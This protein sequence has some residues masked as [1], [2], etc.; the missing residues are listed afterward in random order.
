MA[1]GLPFTGKND[2]RRNN[3][4]RG[5]G[6]NLA[7]LIKRVGNEIDP[8][9]RLTMVKAVVL[10]QY[11]AARNGDS[12][13][14]KLLF[15]RGWGKVVQPVEQSGELTIKN[16]TISKEEYDAERES[17]QRQIAEIDGAEASAN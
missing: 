10:G 1:R 17:I 5:K 11:R 12:A 9:T 3:K 8:E 16:R 6:F 2:P 4:G 14:A 7:D 15:E 13:A